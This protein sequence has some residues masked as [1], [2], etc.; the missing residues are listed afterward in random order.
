MYPQSRG[1]CHR[2]TASKHS[3][4]FSAARGKGLTAARPIFRLRLA[5]RHVSVENT[6]QI[7]DA[8][9]A[10]LNLDTPFGARRTAS[11]RRRGQCGV[12]AEMAQLSGVEMAASIPLKVRGRARRDAAA[13]YLSELARGI[14]SGEL[15]VLAGPATDR[16]RGL[17]VPEP[18]DRGQ[19][20]PARTSRLRHAP[21]AAAGGYRRVEH[22]P[23][24]AGREPRARPKRRG[25]HRG[26]VTQG[27]PGRHPPV[28]RRRDTRAMTRTAAGAERHD[29]CPPPTLRARWRARR[30]E[31]GRGTRRRGRDRRRRAHPIQPRQ[32]RIRGARRRQRHGRPAPGSRLPPRHRPARHHGSRAER[33]GG[34][35][36]AQ[37][38]PRHARDPDHHGHGPC[39]GGRQGA[40]LRAGRR[41]LRDQAVLAP[42][43]PRADPRRASPWQGR[44]RGEGQERPSQGGRARDRPPSLRGDA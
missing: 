24:P 32:G 20:S 37:A 6:L 5:Y 9:I 26:A 8:S 30:A 3:R 14:L 35:P 21:L 1:R 15:A 2:V 27:L 11:W 13:F 33:L 41:R 39:R 23:L 16:R 18:R 17:R 44:R 34:L 22:Q 31:N 25:A 28:T 10:A 36:A 29:P 42:G 19:A 43:A 4:E 12:A 40:R 7:C 38:G